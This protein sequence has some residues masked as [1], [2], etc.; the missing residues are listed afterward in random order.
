MN[1]TV[2]AAGNLGRD[3]MESL[4]FT[5]NKLL[6]AVKQSFQVT[7]KLLKDQTEI[8]G[9]TTI[10]CKEPT[11]RSTIPLCDKAIEISNAKSFVFADSVLCL[12]SMRDQPVEAWKNQIKWYLENLYL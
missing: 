3:N 12:G 9:L 4:R 5:K 1:V 7:E 8:S 2:Q 6:K 10:D 11:W